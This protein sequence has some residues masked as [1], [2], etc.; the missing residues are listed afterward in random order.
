[1][2]RTSEIKGH[3]TYEPHMCEGFWGF[4]KS[5]AE[6]T[7]SSAD[8]L[9]PGDDGTGSDTG[10]TRPGLVLDTALIRAHL[11]KAV[12]KRFHKIH[13]G[14]LGTQLRQMADASSLPHQVIVS[15]VLNLLHIMWHAGIEKGAVQH[16]TYLGLGYIPHA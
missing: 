3:R 12:G 4:G 10:A 7:A 11:Q 14:A 16:L 1:M 13:V 8:M 6:I 15:Q 2:Y 5:D 9:A